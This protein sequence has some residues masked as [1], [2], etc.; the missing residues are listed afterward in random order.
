MRDEITVV[1]VSASDVRPL[2]A[3][4]LR[5]GLPLSESVYPTDDEEFT[6]HLAV[7]VDGVIVAV[8]TMFPEPRTTGAREQRIRGMAV[9]ASARSRGYGG[10][11]LS[12]FHKIAL[13][14]GTDVIWC[15][16]RAR[17]VPFYS[18]HHY[19]VEGEPFEL[20]NIGRHF[21]MSRR[22]RKS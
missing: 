7:K 12:A 15:N 21:V 17:A 14:D 16:A 20:P 3:E 2:R 10:A 9:E 18:R 19:F 11:I 22:V 1:R 5:K 8:G 6:T 4:V 13:R